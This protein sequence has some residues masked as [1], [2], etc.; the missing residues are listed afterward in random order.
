MQANLAQKV[1][2]DSLN[3]RFYLRKFSKILKI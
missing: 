2:F 1:K 3:E